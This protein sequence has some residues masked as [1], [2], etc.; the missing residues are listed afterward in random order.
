MENKKIS[1]KYNPENP[2]LVGGQAVIEGVMMKAPNAI[3][4]AV[5]KANGEIAIKKERP[6]V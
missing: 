6:A 3:A 2:L 5:R 1:Y 4:T